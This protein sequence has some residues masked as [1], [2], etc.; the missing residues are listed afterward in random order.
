MFTEVQAH[1]DK[2][3]QLSCP[4]R[5]NFVLRII[6]K[7]RKS[8]TFQRKWHS[9]VNWINSLIIRGK[10]K[11]L[12]KLAAG[13]WN[14][15]TPIVNWNHLFKISQLFRARF[16]KHKYVICDTHFISSVLSRDTYFVK[17]QIMFALWIN[18][19]FIANIDIDTVRSINADHRDCVTSQCLKDP[20][21]AKWLLDKPTIM[22][23]D[24]VS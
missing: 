12:N 23:I 24:I 10:Q 15:L 11:E 18:F 9:F 4:W 22:W 7:R 13:S 3:L 2:F 14:Q 19:L 5:I 1:D 6:C 8:K 16:R 20:D 17:Q 21:S